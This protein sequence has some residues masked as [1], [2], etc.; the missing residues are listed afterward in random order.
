MLQIRLNVS[1][2]NRTVPAK[3]ISKD[4]P[5]WVQEK[6]AAYVAGIMRDQFKEAIDKQR[7]KSTWPPLSEPYMDWK[8]KHNLSL[9]I[10]EATGYLKKSIVYRKRNG[11]Y[12]VGIDPYKRYKNGPKVLFVAKCIEYGTS[13]MPAR[14]LFRPIFN[15]IRKHMG[16]YWRK[17]LAEEN[18]NPEEFERS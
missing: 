11:Y 9:N 7:F 16:R 6:F 8:G 13:R 10:W 17:F 4:Y 3:I 14:P 12:L 1:Q 5:E 15:Q 2:G 18:I